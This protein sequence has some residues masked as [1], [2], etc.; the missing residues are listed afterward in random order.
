[1]PGPKTHE[2][3]Y[4]QLKPLL[5]EEMLAA[6][7]NY[8]A[9]SLYGQGHDLL[10]YQDWWK[11]WQLNQHI[12]ESLLLQENSIQEF[13]FQFLKEAANRNVLAKEQV[14]LF[15]GPGYL[16]HHILDSNLH[17]LII[18]YSG[19]HIRK[20]EN[21]TWKHGIIENLLDVYLM[22]HSENLDYQTYPAY[23]DFC[24]PDAHLDQDVFQ[25][26]TKT[27]DSVYGISGGGRKFE[28][29]I[30]QMKQFVRILKY[31]P[32][33]IKRVFFNSLD[34][35]SKGSASF[36]YHVR[37]EDAEE[38]LNRDHRQWENPKR[39]EL[40]CSKS[41]LELFQEALQASA[42]YIAKLDRLCVQGNITRETV[43]SVVPDQSST[44]ALPCGTER[45][46]RTRKGVYSNVK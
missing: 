28:R 38:Y 17:P 2:I 27:L 31:D 1:M 21:P 15:I 7:P 35:F 9:Y 12:Q 40:S 11:L 10:I 37:A 42:E 39:P 4:R 14:R 34:S 13:V 43:Y 24:F 18:Y 29:A 30:L 44:Y 33:G 22:E 45:R 19:D 46:Y 23:Q 6:L 5:P 3:F 32:S 16:S 26:L 8:D 41:M 36:S 20:K 25:I